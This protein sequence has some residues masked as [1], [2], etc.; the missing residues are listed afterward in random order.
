MQSFATPQILN[1]INC[2]YG[3]DIVVSPSGDLDVSSGAERSQQRVLR[4]LLTAVNG[5][6]WHTEYGAGLPG[7]IGQPSSL[8]NF[9]KLKSNILSNIFLESSVTQNPAPVISMQ[10]VPTGIF[11]QISY[12][13]NPSQ[14]PIVINYTLER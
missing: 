2:N 3:N 4:R 11:I 9:D 6:I 1:D 14:K 10:N 5:Y 8:D 12:T 7:F 13:E